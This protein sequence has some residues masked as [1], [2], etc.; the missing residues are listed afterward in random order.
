MPG[1]PPEVCEGRER[2]E[3]TTVSN[4]KKVEGECT[5]LYEESAQVWTK[6]IE[7]PKM[8][9]IEAKLREAQERCT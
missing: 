9:A 5:K 1:T 6:L 3:M 2:M 7:D 8:K 4:I